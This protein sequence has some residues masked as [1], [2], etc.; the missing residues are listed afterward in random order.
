[1][2]PMLKT[3]RRF[4]LTSVCTL[5]AASILVVPVIADE[6]VG[7]ITKVD[8]EG[9]KVVVTEKGSD[10]EVNV[11]ITD[12]TIFETPKGESK[13]DLEKLQKGVEKSKRGFPVIVT[14]KDGV[15]ERVKLVAKKKDAPKK[16]AP[17]E[18]P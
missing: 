11:R 2:H 7:R 15:A 14:H 4:V 13:I 6:L 10:K 9:K 5:V 1:M 12:E 17:A 18:R 8:V 3:R 16:E